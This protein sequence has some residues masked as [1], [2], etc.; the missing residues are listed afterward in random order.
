MKR[1]TI[2]L[3]RKVNRRK[4]TIW[5][6]DCY[7]LKIEQESSRQRNVAAMGGAPYQ[8]EALKLV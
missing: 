3:Q 7:R 8:R 2:L 6:T 1:N 4:T 5:K